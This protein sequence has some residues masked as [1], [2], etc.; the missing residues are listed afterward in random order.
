MIAPFILL[1]EEI[2]VFLIVVGSKLETR[3]ITKH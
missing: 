3:I 1:R 2:T